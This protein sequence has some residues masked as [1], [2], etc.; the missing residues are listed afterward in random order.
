MASQDNSSPGE[1]T[2]LLAKMKNGNAEAASQLMPLVYDELRHLAAYYM[3]Q[4]RSDHTLQPTA[5][6]HEVFL[7]L[8]AQQ[9][10]DWQSRAHFFAVAAKAMRRI[11]VDHAR[12]HSAEKRGGEHRRVPLDE[13]LVHPTCAIEELISLDEALDRLA[14]WDPQQ[15]RIVELRYFA[16]L[17]VEET[18][19]VLGIGARTV[20]RDWNVARAWLRGEV[21]KKAEVTK[22]RA[23][24][25]RALGAR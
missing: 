15:C 17:T 6:V 25:A 21:T 9:P 14:T 22:G 23:D 18:A 24:D 16:G 12:K 3:R 8:V 10:L 11:L 5:L 2:L 4:E 1:I 13:N 19:S 20:K 7:R